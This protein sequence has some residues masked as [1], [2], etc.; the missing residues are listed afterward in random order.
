MRR[1]LEP[2]R[3]AEPRLE[4]QLTTWQPESGNLRIAWTACPGQVRAVLTVE[5][6]QRLLLGRIATAR[7]SYFG[8]NRAATAA[9]ALTAVNTHIDAL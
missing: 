6:D 7:L 4:D 1:I 8:R 9:T 3:V 5:E 2:H